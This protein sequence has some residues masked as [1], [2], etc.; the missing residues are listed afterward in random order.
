MQAKLVVFPTEDGLNV[1]IWGRWTKGTMRCRYFEDRSEMIATLVELQ[2]ISSEDGK[3]LETFAFTDACPMFTS[4]IDEAV[5][6]A[7]GFSLA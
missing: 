1:V 4:E 3:G 7:H 6:A 5:L 2:L